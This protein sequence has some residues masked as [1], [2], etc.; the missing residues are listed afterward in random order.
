MSRRR[1]TSTLL[2]TGFSLG[3]ATAVSS[4]SVAGA[5]RDE[6]PVVV[7]HRMSDDPDKVTEPVEK[8]VPARWYDNLTKARREY[9]KFLEGKEIANYTISDDDV[10]SAWVS[11][12][13]LD[14]QEPYI[15]IEVIDAEVLPLGYTESEGVPVRI[16]S[17]DAPEI[18]EDEKENYEEENV[19]E[20]ESIGRQGGLSVEDSDGASG[21]LGTPVHD[22]DDVY[23]F[24]CEHIGANMRGPINDPIRTGG[25]FSE[26]DTAYTGF[27][28]EIG[29]VVETSCSDDIAVI[30]PNNDYTPEFSIFGETD[31]ITGRVYEDGLADMESSDE[32]V[33][34]YG[35]TTGHTSGVVKNHSGTVVPYAGVCGTLRTN[36][37]QWGE[38]DDSDDG[39]SGSPV[40]TDEYTDDD[41]ILIAGGVDGAWPDFYIPGDYVFGT[42]AYEIHN[43]YDY[44][45]GNPDES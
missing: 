12:G 21:T 32:E 44:Y 37:L 45:Y 30:E 35:Q 24:T 9:Q 6:V 3:T 4:K 28:T 8:N 22:G 7:A 15:E 33:Q 2:A 19:V 13:T 29:E 39:D 27:G 26:G 36:Q 34:K 31:P 5:K 17:V 25:G 42:A 40:Y 23:F 1:F 41:E 14:E 38:E 11:A 10:F 20:P 43:E 16:E 18:R